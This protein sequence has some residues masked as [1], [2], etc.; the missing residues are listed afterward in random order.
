[1][2][3]RAIPIK[4]IKQ[5]IEQY[6]AVILVQPGDPVTLEIDGEFI[7]EHE[8]DL[9]GRAKL[10]EALADA[11]GEVSFGRRSEGKVSYLLKL[12]HLG[13]KGEWREDA[14]KAVNKGLAA[15]KRIEDEQ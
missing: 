8:R 13:D 14:L 1:M 9:G 12:S 15:I 3:A 5:L 2:A 10:V 11:G 7:V 6:H 4:R